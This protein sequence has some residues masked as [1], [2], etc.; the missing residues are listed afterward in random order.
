[1]YTE[2]PV[3]PEESH[4]SG[5]DIS[6]VYVS[7]AELDALLQNGSGG[8][9][10]LP[11]QP[12]RHMQVSGFDQGLFPGHLGRGQE[13][14]PGFTEQSVGSG[15]K[16]DISSLGAILARYAEKG[17]MFNIALDTY[18]EGG[19]S[20][21]FGQPPTGS[22]ADWRKILRIGREALPAFG[23]NKAR[24]KARE[25]LATLERELRSRH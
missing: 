14:P 15:E 20:M 12:S 2:A 16:I 21:L 25:R 22:V 11:R 17:R 1:M 3:T 4:S 18:S 6:P 8:G 9:E 23:S 10:H 24:R 5:G 7:G 19:F 13:Y